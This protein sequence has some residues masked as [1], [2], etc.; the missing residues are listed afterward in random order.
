MISEKKSPKYL[1]SSLFGN[2]VSLFFFIC[3]KIFF[4]SCLRNARP[5]W[6]V[7][8]QIHLE[9][10]FPICFKN[11]AFIGKLNLSCLEERGGEAIPKPVSSYSIAIMFRWWFLSNVALI[12]Y[13]ETWSAL[14][15]VC[16]CVIWK[17]GKQFN[18]SGTTI[19][20][21]QVSICVGR[22]RFF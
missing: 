2:F 17:L 15:C 5:Q 10:F 11:P 18:K 9:I 1:P 22:H 3:S 16:I 14:C 12:S 21:L 7:A 20:F 13:I 6:S 19:F 8:L 4:C